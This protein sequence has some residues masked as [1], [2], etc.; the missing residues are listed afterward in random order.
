ME[1]FHILT[2]GC[3]MNVRDSNWLKA[4]MEERG[5]KAAGLERSKIIIINSCSVREKPERRI[6]DLIRRAAAAAGNDSGVLIAAAGCVAQQLGAELFKTSPLLRLVFGADNLHK[7]PDE[8]EKA[9]KDP[10]YRSACLS[11]EPL[12]PER[13]KL[14]EAWP[15]GSAFVNIM[16]GCDNFCAYCIVPYVRGRQKSRSKAEILNECARVLDAGATEITLLG[17]NVNAWGKDNGAG[18]FP[19]LLE[20]ISG[21]AGLKRLRFV[22]PH[23]AD[24]DKGAIEAFGRLEN[25]CPRL[26]LPLQSGSD[27]IL[28]RMRRRHGRADYLRLVERL[29]SVRPDI[30]L[31]TD[32][33]VGFPGEDERDFQDTL[34]MMRECRFMNSF[35]FCYSDRPGTKAS[36]MSGKLSEDVKLERLKELQSLQDQLTAEWLEGRAGGMA[37]VLVESPSAKSGGRPQWSGRDEYGAIINFYSPCAAPGEYKNVRITAAGKHSLKGRLAGEIEPEFKNY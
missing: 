21:L 16:Q 31:A 10:D 11:F 1:N 19:D 28:Q 24:L 35:S 14:D 22:T 33:I 17:Q 27:R 12:Y 29:R 13:K 2:F 3:Q 5:F 32:L 9:L 15:A 37:E 25:L 36:Y 34:S 6:K 26:H 8:V 20:E 18:L 30:A 7:I 23:P 4:A